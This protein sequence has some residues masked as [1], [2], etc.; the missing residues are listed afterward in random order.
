MPRHAITALAERALSRSGTPVGDF[1]AP[2]PAEWRSRSF[3]PRPR[4]IPEIVKPA[5]A[6]RTPP[7]E[8]SSVLQ[9]VSASPESRAFAP[10]AVSPR[11]AILASI[12]DPAPSFRRCLKQMVAQL[13]KA[14]HPLFHCAGRIC[15]RARS[16]IILSDHALP[17][18]SRRHSPTS[19]SSIPAE[20]HFYNPVP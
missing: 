18:G 9:R 15:G 17:G 3:P 7:F 4:T 10:S 13:P 20:T 2:S 11:P 1:T 5:R 8:L 16:P 19:P 14:H 6:D 12:R